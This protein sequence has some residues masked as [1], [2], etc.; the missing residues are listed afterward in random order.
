MAVVFGI[1]RRHDGVLMVRTS[2]G[3][4]TKVTLLFPVLEQRTVVGRG[5]D[6][7]W[8]APSTGKVLLVDDDLAVRDIAHR[9][10][11]RR[12]CDIVAA[13]DGFDA[14]S[15]CREIGHD[16]SFVL[17][18]LSMPGLDGDLVYR[19]LREKWPRLP[20]VLMS[21]YASE[22]VGDLLRGD[23]RAHFLQKPFTMAELAHAMDQV[24]VESLVRPS[25]HGPRGSHAEAVRRGGLEYRPRRRG[26]R[27]S[28]VSSAWRPIRIR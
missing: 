21:G 13:A 16:L 11:V 27:T 18:D 2:P 19:G 22:R 7:D 10:L 14:M 15:L 28:P 20:V 9:M 25:E 3:V 17:L 4:G 12:G 24:G 23:E 26:P 6:A 5:E 8:T 1:V